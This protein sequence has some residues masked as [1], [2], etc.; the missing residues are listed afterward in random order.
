MNESG[1]EPVSS[2]PGA[3]LAVARAEAGLSAAQAAERLHLDA[4]TLDA[5]ENGRF[6]GLGASVFVRGHLR[7]YAE[8][9]GIPEAEIL[10]SYDAWSGRLAA[11][12]D[13][14]D[15]ITAPPGRSGTRSFE[16]RPRSALIGA[17][18]LV[19]AALVWWAIRMPADGP[20]GAK[21]PAAVAVPAA[22]KPEAVVL[23]A[24]PAPNAPAAPVAP[25]T[26]AAPPP[27]RKP[28]AVPAVARSASAAA[29]PVPPVAIPLPAASLPAASPPVAGATVHLA[30]ALSQDSWIEVY[31]AGGAPLYHGLART[32]SQ[33]RVA[34]SAPLRLFLG[35]PLAVS[36][37]LNGHPVELKGP[38]AASRPR[39]FSL[40]SNGHVIDVRDGQPRAD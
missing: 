31:D 30:L 12:P 5:L 34:G 28:S 33:H 19:P 21:A 4:R 14:R 16:L 26:Q 27:A 9:V 8:L 23:P 35:N 15:V 1:V 25:I 40:D 22:A 29:T 32:D 17:I 6:E 10:S 7:R 3:R 20:R 36:L 2:S 18:V 11:H 37:E 38:T 39:H 13:L 24:V